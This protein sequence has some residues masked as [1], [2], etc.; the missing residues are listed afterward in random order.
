MK[1]LLYL[2]IILA[3]GFGAYSLYIDD[4]EDDLEMETMDDEEVVMEQAEMSFFITSANPGNGGNL[5]GLEGAD[6]Y[7]AALAESAGVEGKT[8]RAYLSTV[9]ADGIDEV[10]AR[11]RIGSGPWY[12][13]VGELVAMSTDELHGANNLLK[14]TALS[15]TGEVIAGRGDDVNRHDIMTG[16]TMEGILFVDGEN[17]TTCGNW[18][19]DSE[20]SARVGHHDRVG[21][22]DSA[23]MK[24]WNSSHA[25]RG[26]SLD[27]LKSTGGDGL[28]YCFAAN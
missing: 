3:L 9:A 4:R 28:F 5:G 27:N 2:I 24:S 21:I 23:A 6:A 12:N 20:G 15:E 26:C 8:W 13:A 17:D 22:D 18:T 1:K 10:H 14:T 11:D 16:S 25:S 19:S 7:C